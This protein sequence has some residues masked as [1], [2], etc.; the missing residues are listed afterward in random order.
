MTAPP[1]P[2][3]AVPPPTIAGI[4]N[5]EVPEMGM[6]V[7]SD[8]GVVRFRDQFDGDRADVAPRSKSGRGRPRDSIYTFE[9]T[10]PESTTII[11]AAG[12]AVRPETNY[13][14]P[15]TTSYW[16]VPEVRDFPL[17]LAHFGRDFEGISNFM[18]TK[19]TQMVRTPITYKPPS[20]KYS[21]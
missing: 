15:Q 12:A 7:A 3:S 16:S 21:G 2:V 14:S 11:P 4:S 17:L 6:D 1:V 20:G 18:K 13:N 8:V 19:S 10:E 5:T 9:S